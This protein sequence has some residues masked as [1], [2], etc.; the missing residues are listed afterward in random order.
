LLD[1]T[2]LFQTQAPSPLHDMEKADNIS[3]LDD[4]HADAFKHALRRLLSTEVAETT[5][6][7][8]LD[9][10]PTI[11][12]F[13]EFHLL[14][15]GNPVFDLEHTLICS[16][17]VERTRKFRREFDPSQLTLP[18]TVSRGINVLSSC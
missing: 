7:E 10:L 1:L 3:A 16:G 2:K 11:D 9:G 5:Y 13:R 8:I 6:A 17:V 4:E 15:Q 12:S 14:Q 18:S